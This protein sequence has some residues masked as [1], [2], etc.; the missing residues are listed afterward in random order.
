M[1]DDANVSAGDGEIAET[2]T[3][4]AGY[5]RPPKAHQF[6]KGRSG[7]PRGRAKGAKG[8]RKIAEQILLED[9][10]IRENGRKVRRTTLELILITLRNLAFDGNNRAHK[11]FGKLEAEYDPPPPDKPAGCLVVPGRLTKEAWS[12]LYARKGPIVQEE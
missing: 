8:K 10:V 2:P 3:P 12:E 11:L 6:C 7:N 4:T 1:E 9:H 5:G